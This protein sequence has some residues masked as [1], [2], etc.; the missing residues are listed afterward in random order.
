VTLRVAAAATVEE[1]SATVVSA[2]ESVGGT[3]AGDGV[4]W[5]QKV[6]PLLPAAAGLSLSRLLK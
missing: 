1:V 6:V 3:T 2:V 5:Q 4:G